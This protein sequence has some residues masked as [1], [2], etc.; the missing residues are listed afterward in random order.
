MSHFQALGDFKIEQE[1]NLFIV[2]F[3]GQFNYEGVEAYGNAIK[4]KVN[5]LNQ[6]PWVFIGDINEL[7]ISTMDAVDYVQELV[8]WMNNHGCVCMVNVAKHLSNALDH[9]VQIAKGEGAVY[10]AQTLKQA[11]KICDQALAEY[12]NPPLQNSTDS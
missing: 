10:E 5:L 2:T 9:Q 3:K 4:A 8:Q 6:K 1:E 7:D 12:E 11:R